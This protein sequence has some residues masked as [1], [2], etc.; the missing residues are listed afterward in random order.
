MTTKRGSKLYFHFLGTIFLL[1][2][3]PVC[4]FVI[5]TIYKDQQQQLRWYEENQQRQANVVSGLVE[6]RFQDLQN[7]SLRLLQEEVISSSL[8]E[9]NPSDKSSVDLFN[10]LKCIKIISSYLPRIPFLS[11]ILVVSPSKELLI[12]S[13]GWMTISEYLEIYY[14][15]QQ[16]QL[17]Q[18]F[19][20]ANNF[21]I[22][23]LFDGSTL[24]NADARCR[25]TIF[26]TCT[27]FGYPTR[28]RVIFQLDRSQFITYF[29]EIHN[30]FFL[31][32]AI[33]LNDLPLLE[34]ES[35]PEK[36]S[37]EKIYTKTNLRFCFLSNELP[38][39]TS[40]Y[41]LDF[42]VAFLFCFVVSWL[43][44]TF[45]FSPFYRIYEKI[46]GDHSLKSSSGTSLKHPLNLL[47][48]FEIYLDDMQVSQTQLR[49]K[50]DHYQQIFHKDDFLF[51][52]LLIQEAENY[53]DEIIDAWPWF[54]EE[55]LYA[56]GLSNLENKVHINSIPSLA[57]SLAKLNGGC[58]FV[59]DL[60][61]GFAAVL[62][63]RNSSN[64]IHFEEIKALL[65]QSFPQANFCFGSIG[66][67]IKGIQD[68]YGQARYLQ[69]QTEPDWSN[70]TFFFPISIE[71]RLLGALKLLDYQSSSQLLELIFHENAQ[72]T[73]SYQQEQHLYQLLFLLF[74]RYALDCKYPMEKFQMIFKELKSKRDNSAIQQMFFQLLQALIGFQTEINRKKSDNLSE[75][76][77]D[78]VRLHFRDPDICINSV[79]EQFKISRNTLSKAFKTVSE[80]TLPE[81]VNRMRISEAVELIHHSE[82]TLSEISK[83]TGFESY[84]TFKR[85]FIKNMGLP[86]CE[87]QQTTA[88]K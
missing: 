52:F 83:L 30:Q 71:I 54:S 24:P 43:L 74:Q 60:N 13:N 51:Q 85:A 55:G 5:K 86:P 57:S 32:E 34:T 41:F 76:L 72:L 1:L 4:I 9:Y 78:Y 50:I 3:F 48:F 82:Y 17:S 68:S 40:G 49:K 81:L 73:L 70:S 42:M 79:A 84:S 10:R 23:F 80:V 77:Y 69:R 87:Y 8:R 39:F 27:L 56:I 61:G 59:K 31:N 11:D 25:N 47:K 12:N 67:G 64:G 75:Q 7:L 2:F 63:L 65:R 6:T 33:Y 15:N 66:Q 18:V 35:P 19:Q 26:L 46:T 45:F 62:I 28:S 29:S 22:E 53:V 16:E 44:A 38:R 88:E 37:Y 14:P 36:W 21:P 58:H 20:Q